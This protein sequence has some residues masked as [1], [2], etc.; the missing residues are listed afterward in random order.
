MLWAGPPN[1]NSLFREFTDGRDPGSPEIQPVF[2]NGRTVRF[3]DNPEVPAPPTSAPWEGT[4]VLYLSHPSDPITW[5]S[6]DL[7]LRRPDWL[8]EPR[9]ADV[10]PEMVWI[11]FVTFWQVTADMVE[12]VPVPSGHGHSFTAQYVDGWAQVIQPAG[13]TAQKS[14]DLQRIILSSEA[15]ADAPAP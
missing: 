11:P 7:L 9:G 2:R 6:T 4:R 5:W 8:S 15:S 3:A 14:A 1:F 10:L 13:W 12:P